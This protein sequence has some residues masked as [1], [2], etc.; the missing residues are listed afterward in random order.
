MIVLTIMLIGALPVVFWA[1]YNLILES[2][3]E[4]KTLSLFL[5][6]CICAAFI[7]MCMVI[8]GV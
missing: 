5:A 1:F 7:G 3:N 8:L 4:N 2:T 6:L